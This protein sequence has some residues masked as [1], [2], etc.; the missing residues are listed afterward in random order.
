MP[1][2]RR[3]PPTNLMLLPDHFSVMYEP[4]GNPPAVSVI[5]PVYNG[6]RFLPEAINSLLW[7]TCTDWELLIVDDG[8]TDAT[9][10]VV[11]GQQDLRIRYFH[12]QN[13]GVAAARNLGLQQVRGRYFCFLD[14]DD[15]LP[16]NSLESRLQYMEA[17]PGADVLDSAVA[18]RDAQLT[19]TLRQYQPSYQGLWWPELIRLKGNCFFGINC[20]FR[21]NFTV[22]PQ[23]V[24]VSHGEDLLFYLHNAWRHRLVY[25]SIQE[26]CYVYR[27]HGI[28]AMSNL[29]G[30]AHGYR[31]VFESV[32]QI[33]GIQRRQLLRLRMRI[34]RILFLSFLNER[35][36][37]AAGQQLGA[38][39]KDLCRITTRI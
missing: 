14:A 15:V 26:V 22:L 35:Q 36:F 4:N 5:M 37:A 25:H 11:S 27:R 30:L 8:S 24:G 12:Q 19:Q 39:A 21:N 20:F 1:V 34:A 13:A 32:Q 2:R 10:M 7:Q 3:M 31:Q 28:T 17:H 23:P 29:D 9:R 16:G 33:P 6:A 38:A 18:V